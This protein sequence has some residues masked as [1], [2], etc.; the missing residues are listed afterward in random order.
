MAGHV[1]REHLRSHAD[2]RRG[3]P[4]TAGCDP[5]GGDEIGGQG[6]HYRIEWID[7]RALGGEHRVRGSDHFQYVAHKA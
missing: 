3:K 6:N 5:H 4:D 1:Q 7:L 2:L